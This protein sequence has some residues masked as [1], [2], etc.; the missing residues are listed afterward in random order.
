MPQSVYCN[1][2]HRILFYAQIA[3]HYRYVKST[4]AVNDVIREAHSLKNV[5]EGPESLTALSE[6]NTKYVIR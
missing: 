1:T 2:C 4:T 6:Q 5:L 3:T